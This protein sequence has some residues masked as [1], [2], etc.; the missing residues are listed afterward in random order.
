VNN[1]ELVE[2]KLLNY[3][4]AIVELQNGILR[5]QGGIMALTELRDALQ[6]EEH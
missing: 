3:E 4:K 1:L 6:K 5:L 2:E